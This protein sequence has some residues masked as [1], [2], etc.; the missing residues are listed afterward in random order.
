MINAL[1]NPNKHACKKH[2]HTHTHPD[3]FTVTHASVNGQCHFPHDWANAIK[4]LTISISSHLISHSQNT[5]S[6]TLYLSLNGQHIF[7]FSCSVIPHIKYQL[8]WLKRHWFKK[9]SSIALFSYVQQQNQQKGHHMR[10]HVIDWGRWHT[11]I[12]T[13]SLQMSTHT[14]THTHIGA[15]FLLMCA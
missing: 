4:S 8:S 6:Q 7:S 14:H 2:T 5:D 3:A 10:V 1:T 9:C 11:H 13:L 15:V 12:C